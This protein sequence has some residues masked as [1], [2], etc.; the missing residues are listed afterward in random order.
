MENKVKGILW[1]TE[2]ELFSL[3]LALLWQLQLQLNPKIESA[4]W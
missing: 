2:K 4:T 1:S 3:A